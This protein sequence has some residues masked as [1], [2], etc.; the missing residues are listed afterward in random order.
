MRRYAIL[1]ALLTPALAAQKPAA[2]PVLRPEAFRHYIETFN[3]NDDE[4]FVNY[5]DD[6]T[7]WD[8][9]KKNIPLFECSDKNLE[10]IYYFRWWT[11][12]KHIKKTPDGFVITEFLPPVPWAGKYNTISCAAGH[13]LLRGPMAARSGVSG[14]LFALL[15]PGRQ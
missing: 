6:R 11:Y 10:E 2:G 13:H 14:R 4:R 12:R 7:S 8:W 3:R 15:V 9:L 5:I 1:L